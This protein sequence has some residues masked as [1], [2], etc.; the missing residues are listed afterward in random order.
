MRS[1]LLCS[2]FTGAALLLVA[3]ARA[4]GWP[5]NSP[6]GGA[7]R[8]D[9][10]QLLDD[11]GADM[12]NGNPVGQSF[13]PRFNRLAR[14]TLS[15]DN[16]NDYRPITL[17][18][19][20]WNEDRA[21]TVQAAPI[22]QDIVTLREPGRSLHSVFPDLAVTPGK[23]YYLE[24]VTTP[25]PGDPPPAWS[26]LAAWRAPADAPDPYPDGALFYNN[27]LREAP[28]SDQ[29]ADLALRT[30]APPMT[31]PPTPA[32][33]ASDPS[34]P[35]NAPSPPGPPPTRADYLQVILAEADAARAHLLTSATGCNGKYSERYALREAFLQRATGDAQYAQNAIQM[36]ENAYQ[37][38][39]CMVHPAAHPGV[40]PEAKPEINLEMVGLSYRMLLDGAPQLLTPTNHAHIRWMMID[41]ARRSWAAR[42]YGLQNRSLRQA[43]GAKLVATLCGKDLPPAEASAFQAYADGTWNEFV[44]AVHSIPPGAPPTLPLEE[45]SSHY[46]LT[47]LRYLL[48]LWPFYDP[49]DELWQD[50]RFKAF[51]DA[52]TV[53]TPLGPEPSAG[54]SDGWDSHW[55]TLTWAFERAARI[56][57]DPGYRWLAYRAFDYHRQHVLDLRPGEAAYEDLHAL[58]F[59]WADA[60][61]S[62]TPAP[63]AQSEVQDA[64]SSADGAAVTV[65]QASPVGQTFVATSDSLARLSVKVANGG[66]S[67]AP[68]Y[69]ALYAWN[70]SR[71][72]TVLAPPLHQENFSIPGSTQ[73]T[74]VSFQP[75]LRLVPGQTYYVELGATSSQ[76][77]QA[78]SSTTDAYPDGALQADGSTGQDLVFATAH[79]GP[80]GS[81]VTARLK[82]VARPFSAIS[83]Q[84]P[85]WFSLTQDVVPD[86]MILRSGG[87]EDAFTAIVNLVGTPAGHAHMEVGAVLTVTDDGALLMHDQGYMS[88]AREDQNAAMARRHRGGQFVGIPDRVD[89]ELFEDHR[90]AT[91][92]RIGYGDPDGFSLRNQR[93]FLFVKDRFLLVRD[94]ATVAP[95]APMDLSGGVVWHANDLRPEHAADGRWYDAYYREPL[96]V[97]NYRLKNPQRSLL[98]YQVPRQ[99]YERA[100]FSWDYSAVQPRTPPYVVYQKYDQKNAAGRTF[101][102]DTVLLPH[103]PELSP[104]AAAAS[105]QVIY[106]DAS[107]A[108][109]LRI[110]RGDETWT[111]VDNPG[112]V[113][114]SMLGGQISTDALTLITRTKAG[115]PDYVLMREGSFARVN[116]GWKKA[117]DRSF[118]SV[119]SVEVGGE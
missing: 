83:D 101:W 52:F 56:Y 115:A 80:N 94:A 27:F 13:T 20:P 61:E 16:R 74:T 82:P 6:Y 46:N 87:T 93:S 81:Q 100:E 70:G 68:G 3:P 15:F 73:P 111:V 78:A 71:K 29:N 106:Q 53:V 107:G 116:Q 76:P 105:I 59:A 48:E 99:G 14:L 1:S 109:V 96:M 88:F 12:V 25:Q 113:S 60:D 91:L 47:S 51:L 58:I 49:G 23:K 67:A 75:Y 102:T 44:S 11:G 57:K 112:R 92:A 43:L 40:T 21:T 79:L 66:A 9:Q 7:E 5:W 26:A 110:Q 42:E 28:A 98:L 118:P 38:L 8:L 31:L 72:A 104:N 119:T 37:W 84:N 64:S 114:L 62:I 4:A 86:K 108:L 63:P 22:F 2:A 39:D 69:V 33:A 10:A 24:L 50:A 54:S 17:R 90:R 77:Y 35:F 97:N 65:Q 19:W 85:R 32:F 30:F 45:D 34:L 36:L 103:G 95:G 18:I 117:I 89:V 41:S 55:G